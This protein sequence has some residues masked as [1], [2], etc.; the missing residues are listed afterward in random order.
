MKLQELRR[1][2]V[3][4]VGASDGASDGGSGAAGE[5]GGVDAAREKLREIHALALTE[6]A[7]GLLA[8]ATVAEAAGEPGGSGAS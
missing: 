6:I 5:R 7:R 8:P 3:F 1:P 4:I 2:M